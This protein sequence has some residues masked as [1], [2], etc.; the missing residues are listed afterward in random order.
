MALI[1]IPRFH[2]T[3]YYGVFASRSALRNKL[4]DMP[5]PS[6]SQDITL[7]ENGPPKRP[8]KQIGAR[9]PGKRPIGWAALLKRTFGIDVLA[10]SRCG[11]RMT[12]V[13]VVFD[14]GTIHLFWIS[15]NTNMPDDFLL[16][17]ST[18]SE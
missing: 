4:P 11:S 6:P 13:G 8:L 15:S 10:C 12:L 16:N 9:R 5:E 18:L 17:F 3:R 7:D 14:S 1:P 2:L